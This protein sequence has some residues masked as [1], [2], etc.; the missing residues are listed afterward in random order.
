M[1]PIA[2]ETHSKKGYRVVHRCTSCGYET[3]NK[4]ALDDPTQPDEMDA[5][6]AIVR[7]ETRGH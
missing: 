5:I 3:V 4:L 2:I 6:L 7:G 1:E